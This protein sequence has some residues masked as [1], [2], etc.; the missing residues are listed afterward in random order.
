MSVRDDLIAAKALIDTP[1]KWGKGDQVSSQE[2]VNCAMLAIVACNDDG[3]IWDAINILKG[4]IPADCA[5]CDSASLSTYN[6]AP[7]TTHAD[8]MAWFDRAIA[9]AAGDS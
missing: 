8:V 1:D 9:A 2:N 5:G 7:E 4:Q 3:A 6:D